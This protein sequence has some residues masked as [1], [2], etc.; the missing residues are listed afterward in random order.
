MGPLIIRNFVRYG[1]EFIIAVIT[2]TEFGCRILISSNHELSYFHNKE[3]LKLFFYRY[4]KFILFLEC[5]IYP[6]RIEARFFVITDIRT[7][8]PT[9]FQLNI[10]QISGCPKIKGVA[11]KRRHKI[12]DDFNPP[13]APLLPLSCL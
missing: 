5:K 2:M 12:L 7:Y 10:S 4:Y 6:L 1:H 3:V 13:A 8:K 11:Q 9:L